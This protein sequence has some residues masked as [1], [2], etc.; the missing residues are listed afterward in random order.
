MKKRQIS[1]AARDLRKQLK[2]WGIKI[3]LPDSIKIIKFA[4]GDITNITA[5]AAA[6]DVAFDFTTDPDFGFDL[7][8]PKPWVKDIIRKHKL[9]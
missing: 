6:L 3:N 9:L 4:I 1:R 2:Q 8:D 7:A 5:N